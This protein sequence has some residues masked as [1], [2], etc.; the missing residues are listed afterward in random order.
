MGMKTMK[1]R[2][3]TSNHVE[4]TGAVKVM[5]FCRS[6]LSVSKI[7]LSGLAVSCLLDSAPGIR[8]HSTSIPPADRRSASTSR[9]AVAATTPDPAW[10]ASV[11][12]QI[13]RDELRPSVQ[14]R[15]AGGTAFADGPKAHFANRSENLRA[16]FD[17]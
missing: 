11:Q 9:S 1:N 17:A 16:Y 2:N 8:R 5:H 4:S 15:D 3:D 6:V 7:L 10:L 12:E 14:A 13:R